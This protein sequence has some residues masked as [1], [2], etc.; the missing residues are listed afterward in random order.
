[1]VP[2]ERPNSPDTRFTVV[3]LPEPFGPIRPT[4][5]PWRTLRSSPSTALTPPKCRDTPFSSSTPAPPEKAARAQVHD[6]HDERAEQQVA[7]VAQV[8]QARDEEA[9]HEDHRQ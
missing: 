4:I 7:P 9:L 1:M 2:A 8:A 3:L 5:S 6:Q